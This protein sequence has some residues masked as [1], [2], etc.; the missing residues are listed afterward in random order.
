[1]PREADVVLSLLSLT[2][3]IDK[4]IDMG[5]LIVKRGNKLDASNLGD[6]VGNLRRL[7][8]SVDERGIP[9]VN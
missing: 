1:M 7:P 5:N 3:L 9:I 6:G 4:D 2:I 8:Q